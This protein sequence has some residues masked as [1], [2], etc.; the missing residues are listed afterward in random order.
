M[1]DGADGAV[2]CSICLEEIQEIG[3]YTLPCSHQFHTDCI[4]QCFRRG[5]PRCPVCRDGEDIIQH[6]EEEGMAALR[7]MIEDSPNV[8]LLNLAEVA[9][10]LE[11]SDEDDED[12]E[13][14]RARR[15]A[16]ARRNRR[17]RA[18]PVTRDA[19]DRFWKAR[20][21]VREAE[22]KRDDLHRAIFAA[23]REVDRAGRVLEREEQRFRRIADREPTRSSRSR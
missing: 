10:S 2:H 7:E 21:E 4:V 11:E 3:R 9:F 19:R 5:D 6:Q 14:P 15:A 16:A 17:A 8:A 18:S 13:S 1:E 23:D 20:D 22:K 12:V